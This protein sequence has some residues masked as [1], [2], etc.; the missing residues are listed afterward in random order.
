MNVLASIHPQYCVPIAD[1]RKQVE[2][3]KTKPKITVP[4]KV[5]IYETKG[6]MT[7]KAKAMTPWRNGNTLT[8]FYICEGR[9]K[10]IGEFVCD[11]IYTFEFENGGFLVN[12]D[13]A[14]TQNVQAMSC[15]SDYEFRRYAGEKTV[16]GWHISNL[17]I[18]DEPK[19]LSEFYRHDNTYDNAFGYAFE[20]RK[21]SI[22]LKRPP[23]SWCY[24]AEVV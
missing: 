4:F 22:P 7:L 6:R 17:V 12:G 20:D 1:K 18:Y 21:K 16:Y 9:G 24:L 11:A 5:Y 3:R 10:V 13:I 23:Q 8:D 19:G 2:I 14:T 15:L